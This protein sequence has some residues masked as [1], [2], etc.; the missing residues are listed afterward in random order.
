VISPSFQENLRR[1]AVP[2][3]QISVVSNWA[4]PSEITPLPKQNRFRTESGAS[5]SD[6]LLIYSGS[7]SLNSLLEP[8]LEALCEFRREAV[9]LVVVGEGPKKEGIEARAHELGVNAKFLPFQPLDRYGEVLSA[10]DL[11]VVTANAA[12]SSCSVPSKIF[13]H[14]AA[15]TASFVITHGPSELTRLVQECGGGLSCHDGRP[16]TIASLLRWALENRADVETMGQ[17]A[18]EY[19]VRHYS[20]ST[21][22]AAIAQTLEDAVRSRASLK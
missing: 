22:V 7:L 9:R 19:L 5:A 2:D 13:K 21:C 15:G 10:A 1:K 4:D 18:R 11:A 17:R 16:E 12:G 20:R 14:M 8:L 6:L 3:Q